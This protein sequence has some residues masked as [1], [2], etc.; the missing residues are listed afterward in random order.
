MHFSVLYEPLRLAVAMKNRNEAHFTVVYVFLSFLSLFVKYRH[1]TRQI[2][3][4]RGGNLAGAV[5]HKKKKEA[6][7]SLMS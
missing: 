3:S 2:A 5:S 7:P 1:R 4:T 6:V